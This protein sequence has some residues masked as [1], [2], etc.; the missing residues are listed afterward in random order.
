MVST[1]ASPHPRPR[2]ASTDH[3]SHLHKLAVFPRVPHPRPL[4]HEGRGELAFA[5]LV[6]DLPLSPRGQGERTIPH[7]H[8]EE[9]SDE[10]SPSR[11][12][13]SGKR[14]SHGGFACSMS[15]IFFARLQPLI[16]FSRAMAA[17]PWA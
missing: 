8:P 17:R 7:R 2:P 9:R 1:T 10:G 4:S 16:C 5:S 11:V 12:G 6:R 14:S 15:A 13:L 3:S